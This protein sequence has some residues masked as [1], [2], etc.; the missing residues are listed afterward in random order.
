MA[1]EL[2]DLRRIL[3]LA[4]MG[5]PDSKAAS[6]FVPDQTA[7]AFADPSS[8][9]AAAAKRGRLFQGFDNSQLQSLGSAG[10][11][12]YAD[13]GMV[14]PSQGAA[15]QGD[16]SQSGFG[17][18]APAPATPPPGA[19]MDP[20]VTIIS[21]AEAALA[22]KLQGGEAQIAVQK[23]IQMFGPEALK[24]LHQQMLQGRVIQ[25]PGGPTADQVP[26][27][28]D[29]QQPA[30]LSSGEFVMPE[31]AVRGMGGGDHQAGAQAMTQLSQQLAGGGGL[32]Q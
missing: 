10:I 8:N 14:D 24:A 7:P 27:I 12:G 11:T 17:T 29:G 15:P 19:G 3:E 5:K 6:D 9:P 23:F 18:G 22:G 31:A 2:R 20:R 25:G 13:G 26:A 4:T 32:P 28:I 30:K 1:N 21:D 16:P